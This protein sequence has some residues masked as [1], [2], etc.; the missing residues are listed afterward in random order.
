MPFVP[1]D[2]YTLAYNV[3]IQGIVLSGGTL[4]VVHTHVHGNV[5][6]MWHELTHA[7][8]GNDFLVKGLQVTCTQFYNLV[9]RYLGKYQF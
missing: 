4:S 3:K 5:D 7:C 6:I 8:G 2:N 1:G 9:A